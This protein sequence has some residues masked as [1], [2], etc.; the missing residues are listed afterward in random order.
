MSSEWS[1][2]R[3]VGKVEAAYTRAQIYYYVLLSDSYTAFICTYR[4][5]DMHASHFAHI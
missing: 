5:P 4:N 3:V 1:N 2:S